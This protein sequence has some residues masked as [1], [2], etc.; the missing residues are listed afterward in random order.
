MENPKITWLLGYLRRES[1]L[2]TL[3]AREQEQKL[4]KLKRICECPEV[5][6][7]ENVDT[8]PA[9]RMCVICG[10]EEEKW[11]GSYKKLHDSSVIHIISCRDRQE[12]YKLRDFMVRNQWLQKLKSAA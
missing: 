11:G 6:E 10:H 3:Y 1:I 12:F 5:V 7:A 9:R 4:T 2:A 8:L